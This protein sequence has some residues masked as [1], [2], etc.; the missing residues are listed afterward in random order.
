VWGQLGVTVSDFVSSVLNIEGP[1]PATAPRGTA[2]A[3]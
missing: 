3:D 1:T 2:G